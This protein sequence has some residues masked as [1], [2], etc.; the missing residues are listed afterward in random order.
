MLSICP[1]LIQDTSRCFL[2]TAPD[3]PESLSWSGLSFP[4][5]A[6]LAP[7][8]PEPCER[9]GTFSGESTWGPDKP[10]LGSEQILVL[11]LPFPRRG[12]LGSCSTSL[13]PT[14]LSLVGETNSSPDR[15][16]VRNESKSMSDA[17]GRKGQQHR[18]RCETFGRFGS[19]SS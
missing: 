1:G 16:M 13:N 8:G 9:I 7:P 4:P 19:L 12:T 2:T 15:V 10:E 14:V 11:A 17:S 18:I 5:D 6:P 3:P